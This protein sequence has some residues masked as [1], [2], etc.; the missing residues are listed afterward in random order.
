MR[1]AWQMG[2]LDVEAMLDK[3]TRE[4]FNR[5]LVAYHELRLDGSP[6]AALVAATI[7]NELMP[8]HARAGNE[9]WEPQTSEDYLPPVEFGLKP[10]P[11]PDPGEPDWA[12]IAARVWG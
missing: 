8:V 7:H 3:L 2:E 5:W 11:P 6:N 10:Q 1:L 12:T 4:K 9:N